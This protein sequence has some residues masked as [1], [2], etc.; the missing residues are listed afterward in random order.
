M[1]L[2]K[3]KVLERRGEWWGN[4][5]EKERRGNYN[6]NSVERREGV[7]ILLKLITGHRGYSQKSNHII[8]VINIPPNTLNGLPGDAIFRVGLG[9]NNSNKQQ[10]SSTYIVHTPGNPGTTR[11]RLIIHNKGRGEGA[12][13]GGICRAL[14]PPTS[15]WGLELGGAGRGKATWGQSQ[16]RVPR[17]QL[18]AD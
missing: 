14:A 9:D 11:C 15:S 5:N 17:S 7:E 10:A 2:E 3:K 4:W 8:S 12:G 1:V 16:V 18:Y 6:G 13:E